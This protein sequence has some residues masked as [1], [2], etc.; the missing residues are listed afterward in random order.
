LHRISLQTK[1]GCFVARKKFATW[2]LGRVINIVE[3]SL[4]IISFDGKCNFGLEF[5]KN[6]ENNM[7]GFGIYKTN[8]IGNFL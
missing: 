1:L 3:N 4:T 6:Q 5:S 2:K 8:K 7:F